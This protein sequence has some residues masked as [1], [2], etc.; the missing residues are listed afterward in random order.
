MVTGF[1]PIS[2]HVVSCLLLANLGETA[3]YFSLP[4]RVG[5]P[6]LY[7]RGFKIFLMSYMVYDCA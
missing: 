5:I 1:Q 6:V 3:H 7:Q 2:V 4:V